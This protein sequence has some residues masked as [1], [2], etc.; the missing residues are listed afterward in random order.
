MTTNLEKKI[1]NL[2]ISWEL[3]LLEK[4]VLWLRAD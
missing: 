1:M 2:T 3:V 4:S